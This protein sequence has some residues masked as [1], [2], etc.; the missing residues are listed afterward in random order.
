MKND[1]SKFLDNEGRIKIW[2]SKKEMKF[3]ILKYLAG[4]FKFGRF[5]KEQEVNSIINEWHTFNDY[6]LLRRG[7]IDCWF[8]SRTKNGAKYWREERTSFSEIEK[9]ILYNYNIDKLIGMSQMNNGIGSNSYYILCDK[10]EFIFKDIEQNHMNYPENEDIILKTLKE[11]GIPA[12]HIYRTVS[13]QS[14][15]CE[16]NKKYHMQTFVDGIIYRH[17]TAPEWLLFQSAEL[18]GKIQSSMSKLPSLPLGLSQGFLEYL[19][20]ETAVTNHINTLKLAVDNG[21]T[22]IVQILQEKIKLIERYKDL[23]FDFDKMTCRNTH[24]DYSINQIICGK[25]KINAVIDFT[26]A[27]IHPMCWEVIRSYSL[28]DEKCKSGEFDIENFKKYLEYFFKY[29]SLNDYDIKIMPSFYL[30]QNLVCDYFYQ[31]YHLNYKNK[32]ILL[33]NAMCFHEQ[34]K[35]LSKNIE[36]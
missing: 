11:D 12:P 4:K 31:Y 33:E 17:N 29:G 3:E 2:P 14:V 28:A 6:F 1:I 36:N 15:I 24:G 13:D 8:L 27:C 25:D 30:Y 18:L 10:G 21:D 9:I 26:S 16:G 35:F 20:P 22:A 34:C 7:L 32:H 23:T 19:T 5:Y